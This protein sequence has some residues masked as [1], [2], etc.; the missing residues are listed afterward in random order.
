MKYEYVT[1]KE[2][3]KKG[4]KEPEIMIIRKAKQ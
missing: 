3:E 4:M 1:K 2:K